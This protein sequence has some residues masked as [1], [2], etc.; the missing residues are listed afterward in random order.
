[1]TL[2]SPFTNKLREVARTMVNIELISQYSCP[3][4][5]TSACG[6]WHAEYNRIVGYPGEGPGLDC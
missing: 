5:F 6:P 3:R 2:V 1:M 4:G